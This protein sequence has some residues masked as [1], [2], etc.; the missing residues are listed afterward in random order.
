M[1]KAG[2]A[3]RRVF[4]WLLGVAL[5]LIPACGPGFV[6]ESPVDETS[7][8]L[9]KGAGNADEHAMFHRCATKQLSDAE[10]AA[11][12]LSFAR[13]PQPPSPGIGAGVIDVYFHVIEDGAGG[14]MVSDTA[15]A[16]QMQV[17]NASFAFTGWSF[18]L[19]LVDRTASAAWYNGCDSASIEAEMK[20]ALR[21]GSADDLNVYTCGP[22]DG[23]LGWAT[24][25]SSY[26]FAPV[27]DGVVVLDGSLPGGSAAPYNMGDTAV[28]EV[29]HWMGLYHTFQGGCSKSND[30]VSDTPPERIPAYD[31]VA[32]DSCKGG[33]LDPVTNFMDYTGDACMNHFT[34]GQDARMDAQFTAY[35]FNK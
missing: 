23:L 31:C 28:H 11:A 25:P 32:R 8:E 26:S 29:G 2:N 24:F 4:P 27:D 20:A 14:G 12:E 7:S 9:G 15:I 21:Q 30:Y 35:R 33:G 1:T 17:L 13:R 10:S 5:F 19:V 34:A 3:M 18:N 6:P 16:A 22:G